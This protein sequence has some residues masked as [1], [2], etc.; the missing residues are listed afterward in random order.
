M[1]NSQ[2]IQNQPRRHTSPVQTDS[3]FGMM[4]AQAFMG[5]AFGAGVDMAW[6]AAE[7]GSAVRMDRCQSPKAKIKGFDGRPQPNT[8]R[9]IFDL[10]PQSVAEIERARF[11]PT[12]FPMKKVRAFAR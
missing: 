1:Q 8:L 4:L 9:S 11:T 7:I 10:A 5:C 3:L 12:P 2:A 6:E